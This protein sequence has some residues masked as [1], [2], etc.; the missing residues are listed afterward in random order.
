[1]IFVNF[2][3][4]NSVELQNHIYKQ[5]LNLSKKNYFVL[6]YNSTFFN[7]YNYILYQYVRY[8]GKVMQCKKE[9][10]S[11]EYMGKLFSK[12]SFDIFLL[13]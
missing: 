13:K 10:F 8:I 6:K 3:P 2:G 7:T 11:K 1:M 12:V 5:L 4:F 9:Y